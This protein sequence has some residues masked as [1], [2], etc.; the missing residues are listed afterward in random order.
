M[1]SAHDLAIVQLTN[2][3]DRGL[4]VTLTL[5]QVA[6]RVTVLAPG[7]STVLV[8]PPGA[9]WSFAPS[10]PTQAGPGPVIQPD[11]TSVDSG[12]EQLADGDDD[13]DGG[14]GPGRTHR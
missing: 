13:D 12:D 6:R 14:R 11:T 7:Q 1:T 3:T 2:T 9:Y 8:A 5:G 4:E 10:G